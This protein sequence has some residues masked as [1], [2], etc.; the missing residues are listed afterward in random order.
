MKR[1]LLVEDDP[2]LGLTLKERLDSEGYQ[3]H[4]AASASAGSLL[5]RILCPSREPFRERSV[6]YHVICC[7]AGRRG[8]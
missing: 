3:V 8:R 1:L 6:A 4:W 2:T 5:A 7:R